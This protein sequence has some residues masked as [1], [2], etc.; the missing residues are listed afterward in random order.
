M[1]TNRMGGS[2][3]AGRRHADVKIRDVKL[4]NGTTEIRVM[5]LTE[6]EVNSVELVME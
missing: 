5:N 2:G 4:D 1:G 6:I 3:T